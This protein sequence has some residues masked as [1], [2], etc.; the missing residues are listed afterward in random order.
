MY[1]SIGSLTWGLAQLTC[2]PGCILTHQVELRA[3][4]EAQRGK[5]TSWGDVS[6]SPPSYPRISDSLSEGSSNGVFIACASLRLILMPGG[7]CSDFF[8]VNAN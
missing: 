2:T 1:L 6:L 3:C 8:Q 4:G 5:E 7:Y